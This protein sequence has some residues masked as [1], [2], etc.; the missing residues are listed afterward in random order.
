MRQHA[1]VQYGSIS[2]VKWYISVQLDSGAGYSLSTRYFLGTSMP[3][4]ATRRLFPSGLLLRV[5]AI[6]RK[7]IA[8]LALGDTEFRLLGEAPRVP[9]LLL[10][11]CSTSG[12]YFVLV[13]GFLS[14]CFGGQRCWLPTPTPGTHATSKE[15]LVCA[16]TDYNE[17]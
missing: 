12:L 13:S 11:L 7:M 5:C 17:T 4:R 1:M 3:C 16:P 15:C 14:Q 10:T 6:D 2:N 9:A 8:G